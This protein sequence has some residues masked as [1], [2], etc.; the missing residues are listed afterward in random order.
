[1]AQVSSYNVANRSGAQVR[2]DINDIYS[3]IK[4]CNSGPSDPA[5]PEQFML[6]GDNTTGDNRLKIYDGSQFRVIGKVTE[7]NLGLLPRAGGT[8]TGALKLDD[9]SGIST[10]ALS[11]DGD[12]DTGLFRA[13]ANRIG[14]SAAGNQACEINASGLTIRADA[15]G[16]NRTLRLADGDNSHHVALGAPQAVSA[17]I[18]YTLPAAPTNG[19]FL[20]TDAAGALTFQVIAGVPTGAI[21]ALPNN[22]ATSQTG[23]QSNGIPVGYLECAGQS[24][25]RSD[26]AALFAVLGT[27]YGAASANHFNIPDLRG[28]FIRGYDHGR[29]V[30]AGRGIGTAQGAGNHAHSHSVDIN[31]NTP[32]LTGTASAISETFEVSGS[33]TGVFG[34]ASASGQRTP[35]TFDTSGAGQL[36]IDVSHSHSVIGS[37]GSDGFEARPRNIAMMYIIKI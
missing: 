25:L 19:G 5:S 22:A 29:A 37:T 8:M 2:G 28:E 10:P 1:M 3:A 34:K 36:S 32:S 21:F 20:Q 27:K 7:D 35:I 30:D 14:F 4:T 12:D 18:T 9:S 15:S 23:Y 24:V 17:N 11:F 33:T 16:S 31:T 13:G 26:Y 6:F